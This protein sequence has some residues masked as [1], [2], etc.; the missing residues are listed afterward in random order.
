MEE[1]GGAAAESYLP[2]SR[3]PRGSG[4][5]APSPAWRYWAGWRIATGERGQ[6]HSSET[7]KTDQSLR[8]PPDPNT[9]QHCQEQGTSRCPCPAST[10]T[11]P[12]SKAARTEGWP[13]SLQRQGGSLTPVAGLLKERDSIYTVQA[14]TVRTQTGHPWG[15]ASACSLRPWSSYQSNYELR[16]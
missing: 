16:R 11:V 2:C 14:R 10:S 7:C 8:L 15:K 5:W 13:E 3:A 4:R 1:L 9:A 12:G 6:A